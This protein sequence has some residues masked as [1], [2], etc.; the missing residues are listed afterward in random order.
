MKAETN[1]ETPEINI[2]TDNSENR[3]GM[4]TLPTRMKNR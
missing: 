1:T 4:N 3:N 2:K